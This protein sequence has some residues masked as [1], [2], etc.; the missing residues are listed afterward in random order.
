MIHRKTCPQVPDVPTPDDDDAEEEESDPDLPAI[1]S[2]LSASILRG[3]IPAYLNLPPRSHERR[4]L[5]SAAQRTM[6]AEG[7]GGSPWTRRQ[8]TRWL[9]AH[10]G[11]LARDEDIP[12]I[13]RADRFPSFADLGACRAGADPFW[14]DPVHLVLP[15]PDWL[16]R[17][18]IPTNP[19]EPAAV[20]VREEGAAILQDGF[21]YFSQPTGVIG[22]PLPFRRLP[23]SQPTA[24]EACINLFART[25]LPLSFL[26]NQHFQ[27][28][29]RQGYP[30]QA[31][32]NLKQLRDAIVE[33]ARMVRENWARHVRAGSCISLT[34]DGVRPPAARIP[35]DR[36]LLHLFA[37]MAACTSC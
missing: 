1:E 18:V 25:N 12:S 37:A 27:A 7:S 15:A 8:I 23:M 3:F 30:F 32:P 20:N 22:P 16:G 28:F 35:R 26:E 10:R 4:E 33:R 13:P 9:S 14:R 36:A 24:L 19:L 2:R 34:A 29:L 11:D 6:R 5:I 17:T 21:R 31:L